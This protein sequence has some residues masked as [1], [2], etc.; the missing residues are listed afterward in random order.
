MLATS[1]QSLVT[2]VVQIA[3]MLVG[4]WVLSLAIALP[5][6]YWLVE[7]WVVVRKSRITLDVCLTDQL[8][9]MSLLGAGVSIKW[10]K[11]HSISRLSF[12]PG[13]YR[14][15][16]WVLH[17]GGDPYLLRALITPDGH[18]FHYEPL[19]AHLVRLWSPKQGE[20]LSDVVL[21]D[22]WRGLLTLIENT[23]CRSVLVDQGKTNSI[24]FPCLEQL[25]QIGE[26]EKR[27]GEAWDKGN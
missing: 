12:P 6:L 5:L 16:E 10:K 17:D 8:P 15:Q 22:L 25:E 14:R 24:L 2:L 4:L 13:T 26:T 27:Q 18:E 1:T 7:R 9:I 20:A 23:A 19:Q 21:G 3:L 11:Q